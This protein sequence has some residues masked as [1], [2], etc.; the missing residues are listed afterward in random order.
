MKGV[1]KRWLSIILFTVF[2][3][4]KRKGFGKNDKMEKIENG[5][6]Y[7]EDLEL[8]LYRCRHLWYPRATLVPQGAF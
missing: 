1:D 6:T 5:K 3:L 8:I 4:T 2:E 7:F